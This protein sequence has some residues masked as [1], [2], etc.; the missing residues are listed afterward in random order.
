MKWSNT[1]L[2][3]TVL[4]V[5]IVFL[6]IL[7]IVALKGMI[8]QTAYAILFVVELLPALVVGFILS[9]RFQAERQA[10]RLA[11]RKAND[12][13]INKIKVMRTPEGTICEAVTALLIIGALVAGLINHVFTGGNSEAIECIAVFSIIAVVLLIHAY[14]PIDYLFK[15]TTEITNPRQMVTVVWFNR[16]MAIEFALVAFFMALFPVHLSVLIT[17]LA[18]LL[19]VTC[20]V[21][22]VWFYRAD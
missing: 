2:L 1:N 10:D 20:C 17:V 19:F 16:V 21:T 9:Q 6:G 11:K 14:H 18:A 15:D 7:I 22:L 4:V 8:S 5:S 12:F 3:L 13:D